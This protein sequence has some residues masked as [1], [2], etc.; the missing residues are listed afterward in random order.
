MSLTW[1]SS[2]HGLL[3]FCCSLRT[4]SMTILSKLFSGTYRWFLLLTGEVDDVPTCA[5]E[6]LK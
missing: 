3:P 4:G 6:L 1:L 2:R 5:V